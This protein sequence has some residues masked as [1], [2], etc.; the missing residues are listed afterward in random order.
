M[1]QSDCYAANRTT[2]NIQLTPTEPQIMKAL[3]D[4]LETVL[5]SGWVVLQ[6]QQNRA[7]PPLPPFALMQIIS[8][9]RKATNSRE[10]HDQSVTIIQS[11]I[12]SIQVTLYGTGAGDG[13]VQLNTAWRDHDAVTFFRDVLPEAA[14]LYGSEPR[15]H[16][17]TTAEKQYEDTWSL[18][19]ALHVNSRITRPV[20]SAKELTMTAE[21]ADKLLTKTETLS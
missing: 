2:S 20:E 12:M 13:A 17:F 5:P 18:D 4:W 14:P 9:K 15:Q 6:A 19:L 3:G 10:Y 7:T 1:A 21:S 16:P 11:L 8:R